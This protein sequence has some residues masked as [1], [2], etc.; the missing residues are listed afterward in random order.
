MV[1]NKCHIGEV[2]ILINKIYI[3][4][5]IH[6]YRIKPEE[7]Y[8]LCSFILPCLNHLPEYRST[9]KEILIR[10]LTRSPDPDG[11]R[12]YINLHYRLSNFKENIPVSGW[13]K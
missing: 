8:S 1:I 5:Y 13:I 12:L 11:C 7:A 3:Y 4:I 6:R 2:I 10:E 9:A